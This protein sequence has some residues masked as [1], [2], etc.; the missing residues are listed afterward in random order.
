MTSI[1]FRTV[2]S[3]S[4]WAVTSKHFRAVT[5]IH[6]FLSSDLQKR[7][8]EL[9]VSV[10]TPAAQPQN[11]WISR[12]TSRN[13]I[14]QRNPSV[15]DNTLNSLK[16]GTIGSVIRKSWRS[17]PQLFS[18]ISRITSRPVVNQ[19]TNTVTSVIRQPVLVSSQCVDS[20]RI[21]I[22]K[23][24]C[25]DLVAKEGIRVCQSPQV[26]SICCYTCSKYLK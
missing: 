2:T 1:H 23:M 18:R 12:Q 8:S 6:F 22:N 26:K 13:S 20:K 25:P 17:T 10:F 21:T 5:N 11:S 7:G 3:I 15:L 14:S 19:R 4:F 9:G 24:K 16:R